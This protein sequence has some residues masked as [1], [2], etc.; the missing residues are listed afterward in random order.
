MYRTY[1][2]DIRTLYGQ[3][4]AVIGLFVSVVITIHKT[5]LLW[6]A[7]L[8]WRADMSIFRFVLQNLMPESMDRF[9]FNRRCSPLE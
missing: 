7:G 1:D 3:V 8:L 9:E 4:H 2:K 6:I 5:L